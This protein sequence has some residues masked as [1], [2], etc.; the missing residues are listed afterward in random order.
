MIKKGNKVR[1][2]HVKSDTLEEYD[3]LVYE[4]TV[5]FVGQIGTVKTEPVWLDYEPTKGS[6]GQ[7]IA[8]GECWVEFD[9]PC[10]QHK[11]TGAL[12]R[13]DELEIVE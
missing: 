11:E 4:H 5:C 2:V 8:Y 13:V 9:Q 6:L 10:K 3:P 1:V 12:F 7:M